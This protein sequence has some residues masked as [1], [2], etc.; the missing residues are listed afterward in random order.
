MDIP[1]PTKFVEIGQAREQT[2]SF[3]LK[4]ILE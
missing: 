2:F 3:S 4:A 1:A